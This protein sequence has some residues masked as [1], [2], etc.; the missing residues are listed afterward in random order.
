VKMGS[1]RWVKGGAD[2]TVGVVAHIRDEYI[3]LFILSSLPALTSH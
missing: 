2:V 1:R 3:R